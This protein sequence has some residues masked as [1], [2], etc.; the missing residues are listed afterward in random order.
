MNLKSP[1]SLESWLLA[2][3][4]ALLLLAALLWAAASIFI[5]RGHAQAAS[6]GNPGVAGV[7]AAFDLSLSL[8]ELGGLGCV[9]L[10]ALVSIFRTFLPAG[11]K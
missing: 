11:P 7:Y 9:I 3:G 10:S 8:L 1:R 2:V 4:A 5:A 6:R